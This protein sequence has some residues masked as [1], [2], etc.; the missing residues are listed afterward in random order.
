MRDQELAEAGA[1]VWVGIAFAVPHFGAVQ[2]YQRR[3]AAECG[4]GAAPG[5]GGKDWLA[6]I[7]FR[8]AEQIGPRDRDAGEIDTARYC[9]AHSGEF[10]A[11]GDDPRLRQGQ[12]EHL[13]AGRRGRGDEGA[14]GG[15]GAGTKRLG[16]CQQVAIQPHTA[17]WRVGDPEGE[18]IL[19]RHVFGA[20]RF[21]FRAA[22]AEGELNCVDMR[23]V[24]PGY[25]EIGF[26]EESQQAAQQIS[27]FRADA[28]AVAAVGFR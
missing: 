12:N 27:T 23:F 17:A 11:A 5:A 21:H 26:A 19:P 15:A 20:T 6:Q 9:G 1:L 16:A 7:I 8:F 10:D 22:I 18:Q 13:G 24:Q 25:G 28:V 14:G 4:G 3:Q 2:V